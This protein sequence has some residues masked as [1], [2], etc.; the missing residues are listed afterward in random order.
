MRNEIKRPASVAEESA[1]QEATMKYTMTTAHRSLEV[2]GQKM[3]AAATMCR[4]CPMVT[5]VPESQEMSY[6]LVLGNVGHA[7]AVL[8]R[9]GVPIVL[10]QKFLVNDQT[11]DSEEYERIRDAGAIITEVMVRVHRHTVMSRK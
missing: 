3:G 8:C 2:V 4:I 1:N 5:A 10:T 7:E 11:C 6:R 9:K